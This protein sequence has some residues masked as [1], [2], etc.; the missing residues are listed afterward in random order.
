MP[1]VQLP[2]K[3]ARLVLPLV[4]AAAQH[5]GVLL[6]Y[7]A[8]GQVKACVLE[9]LA[10]VQPLG[11]CVEYIDGSILLHVLLHVDEGRK[12]ELV[13]LVIR[14][15]VVLDLAGRF[16]HIDVI[17]RIRQH[18]IGLLPRHQPFIGF[19]QRRIATDD[20]VVT[21]EP[22]ISRTGDSRLCQFAIDIKVIF[23]DFLVVHFRE[24][25]L[26]FRC[27]KAR[28]VDVEVDALQIDD[29]VGQ[30]L[31]V[32][33]T[34]DFIERN[35]ERLDLMLILDMDNDTLDFFVAQIL[36]YGQTLM[37]ADDRHIVI[38]DDGFHIAKLLNGL[39]DF[40]VFL[41]AR[42]QLLPGVIC[43]RLQLANGQHLPFHI[44]CLHTLAPL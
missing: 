11:I 19:R 7:A 6:P 34:R 18:H 15:I 38:D 9:C 41:V 43:R 28:Q 30:E 40:L 23:L 4:R 35:V 3:K 8:A 20:A 31:F 44:R 14:H 22:D 13:K 25:L 27:F 37:P 26:D 17:R 2:A 5:Q 29:E 33:G 10:E 32:P 36:Q 1:A 16:F 42:L 21:Q 12:K 39:L 24:E